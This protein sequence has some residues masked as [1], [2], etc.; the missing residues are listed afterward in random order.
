MSKLMQGLHI[1]PAALFLKSGE[2]E[3]FI[4]QAGGRVGN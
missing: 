1:Y 4:S 2:L 3:H